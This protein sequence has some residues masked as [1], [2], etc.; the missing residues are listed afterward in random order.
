[1]LMLETMTEIIGTLSTALWGAPAV[2]LLMG[3]GIY[4]TLRLRFI[5]C[6]GFK[7]SYKILFGKVPDQQARGET[8]PFQALCTSLSATVGTG[9]IAGVATAIVLGGPG[10]MFW[11]WTTAFVGMAMQFASSTLA[12]KYRQLDDKGQILGGP[13]VVLKYGLNMP[14][15]GMAYALFTVMASFGIGSTVQSNSIVGGLT[16]LLPA[17]EAY[18]I[19]IGL[20]LAIIIGLV[21]I[22]GIKRIAKVAEFI[23]PFMAIGYFISAGMILVIFA[24]RILPSFILILNHAF[25]VS[26]FGGAAVGMAIRYGIARGVFSNEAG[27]G[28]SSIAHATAKTSHPV[29]QGLVAMLSPFID[30]IVICTLTGMVLVVTGSWGDGAGDL[31]GAAL[32]AAA[33]NLGTEKIGFASLGGWMV[34]GSLLFFAFS[35]ILGWSYY[36]DRSVKFLLGQWAI[37][38]YRII[39]CI[40][41]VIGAVF[42][43]QLVWNFA[44]IANILM[45]IPNLICIILLA[46]IVNAL[47]KT[48]QVK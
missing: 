17:L 34:A 5:Q 9:N 46:S 4:L 23:V 29:R 1:M 24:D 6:R 13:M 27:L 44:D 3:T 33:F 43:L 48:T 30:T 47:E 8:T 38:P 37:L 20:C 45:A 28:S 7:Q 26:A 11:M 25:Y 40:L 32:T 16:Y 14:A 2:I 21:I 22:G 10:A 39:F 42:P 31:N 15:L 36:G 35:T 41:I 18:K 19:Y 12:V